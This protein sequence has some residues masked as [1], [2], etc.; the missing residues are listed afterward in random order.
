MPIPQGNILFICLHGQALRR[1]QCPIFDFRKEKT[2][3][4]VLARI[5]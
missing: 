4:R 1:G 3:N 2:L 5:L